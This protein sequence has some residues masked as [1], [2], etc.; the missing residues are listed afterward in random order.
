LSENYAGGL[1]AQARRYLQQISCNAVRMGELIDDILDFARTSRREMASAVVGMADL[2]REVFEE[3][4]RAAPQRRIELRL[5]DLPP[6][7]GDSAMIRQVLVNLLSNAVKFTAARPEAV[8][9]VGGEGMGEQVTYRVK[10]NG[11]GFDMQY[12]HNLFGVFQRLHGAGQFE[13]T[14]IG[15]AIVKHIIERHGGRVWAESQVDVGTSVYFTLP[16]A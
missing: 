8:I 11:A 9:E 5:G 10:D 16:R 2:T 7:M 1:G 12:A 3:A 4:C 6:A 14:G 15:L 13:G